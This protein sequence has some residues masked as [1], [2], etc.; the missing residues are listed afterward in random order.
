MPVI[1][2]FFLRLYK[3]SHLRNDAE[4][5]T[6]NFKLRN[7]FADITFSSNWLAGLSWFQRRRLVSNPYDANGEECADPMRDLL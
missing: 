7:P 2:Q 5:R 1:L 3:F 4:R 6:I